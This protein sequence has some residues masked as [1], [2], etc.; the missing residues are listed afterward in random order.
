MV[1]YKVYM[2]FLEV[3]PN[4]SMQIHQTYLQKYL[5]SLHPV[6]APRLQHVHPLSLSRGNLA[7]NFKLMEDDKQDHDGG[8]INNSYYAVH[9]FR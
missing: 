2:L 3:F 9:Q 8:D 5:Q 7:N 1:V 4:L 6:R